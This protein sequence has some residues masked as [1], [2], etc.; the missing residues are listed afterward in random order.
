M[1]ISVITCENN[2][3]A[4]L[5]TRVSHTLLFS[6]HKEQV[7]YQEFNIFVIFAS[8]TPDLVSGHQLSLKDI[9][10]TPDLLEYATL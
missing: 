9:V 8:V 10:T 2:T 6:F 7:F 4:S 1:V 3:V 5:G